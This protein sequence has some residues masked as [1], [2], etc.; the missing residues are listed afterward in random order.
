MCQISPKAIVLDKKGPLAICADLSSNKQKLLIWNCSLC[1]YWISIL[2]KVL[3]PFWFMTGIVLNESFIF[4][5]ESTWWYQGR[6]NFA[7]RYAVRGQNELDV[8]D[9]I[10][11]EPN[12]CTEILTETQNKEKIGEG[13]PNVTA[14]WHTRNAT[15]NVVG[16]K[17]RRSWLLARP[18]QSRRMRPER[19]GERRA[20]CASGPSRVASHRVRGV[21]TVHV[22]SLSGEHE[23]NI[24]DRLAFRAP[25]F[26]IVDCVFPFFRFCWFRLHYL[27][28]R[29]QCHFSAIFVRFR[30]RF[31]LVGINTQVL[32]HFCLI[33]PKVLLSQKSKPK[34]SI[35]TISPSTRA[36][37]FCQ[38]IK[39]EC[40]VG[41]KSRRVNQ[42]IAS[43]LDVSE[44]YWWK[45]E[46][47]RFFGPRHFVADGHGCRWG[48]VKLFN[49]SGLVQRL[50][51]G[52]S[53]VI[54]RVEKWDVDENWAASR[55]PKDNNL[56][57][58]VSRGQQH[59]NFC[60]GWVLHV[61]RWGLPEL[62]EWGV[63]IVTSL[64][65]VSR[66]FNK[67]CPSDQIWLGG[68]ELT[69]VVGPLSLVA[70]TWL[71]GVFFFFKRISCPLGSATTFQV[72]S[73]SVSFQTDWFWI[74]TRNNKMGVHTQGESGFFDEDVEV[75]AQN[76]V[77][78]QH[79][80]AN[81]GAVGKWLHR[82]STLF[83]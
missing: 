44:G 58:L 51:I 70:L 17:W 66:N 55:R 1:G 77:V 15:A 63:F 2:T 25:F 28:V 54:C 24:V 33:L 18:A 29:R 79:E 61:D 50:F 56:Q 57:Q 7:N 78:E 37:P 16:G 49:I 30:S 39:D 31:F 46:T 10:K 22:Q 67:F 68:I 60:V 3:H 40:F 73:E 12:I 82:L 13:W 83:L 34:R 36:A 21:L 47:C 6:C 38:P 14:R 27:A 71:F 59:S 32:V 76:E 81:D 64:D 19:A 4:W 43:I 42:E 74:K 45:I 53:R 69:L 41:S 75:S 35:K 23:G 26:S 62:S 8:F 9:R 72:P 80:P 11:V 48:S 52:R 5:V 20:E 65:L